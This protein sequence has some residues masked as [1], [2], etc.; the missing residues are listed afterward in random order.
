ML[1]AIGVYKIDNSTNPPTYTK[2]TFA[3]K[4]TTFIGALFNSCL[5]SAL[6][7]HTLKTKLSAEDLASG[8]PIH[9]THPGEHHYLKRVS[10]EPYL[11]AIC[12]RTVLD[13]SEVYYLLANTWHAHYRPD[14]AR[15]TMPQIIANPL[16]YSNKDCHLESTKQNT[17]E[18][19]KLALNVMDKIIERGEKLESLHDRTVRLEEASRTFEEEAKKLKPCC[20]G[21]FR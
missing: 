9:F 1:I 17:E 19:K 11:I 15:V 5:L 21:G 8:N 14:T 4:E 12:A 20:G 16:A 18:L 13:P 10:G 2:V 3:Q 6:E 7:D